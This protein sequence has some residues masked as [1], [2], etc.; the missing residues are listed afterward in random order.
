MAARDA[1]CLEMEHVHTCVRHRRMSCP[2][3]PPHTS[4]VVPP[5][6]RY[7]L[8]PLAPS[9][10]ASQM[11]VALVDPSINTAR[12][13]DELDRDVMRLKHM[14]TATSDALRT[15]ENRLRA[16]E[17]GEPRGEVETA[18]P[19]AAVA[20]RGG[21]RGK[22][23]GRGRGGRAGGG[24]A[25]GH[26]MD[27]EPAPGFAESA[28]EELRR[29]T[30]STGGPPAGKTRPLVGKKRNRQDGGEAPRSRPNLRS[31]SPAGEDGVETPEP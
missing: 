23:R 5:C 9:S 10:P 29:Q 26:G 21:G 8:S 4:L 14:C 19:A 27:E 20:G 6:P 31:A 7:E 2:I 17:R 12:R 13:L 24:A 22:G 30:R 18:E 25:R 1:I 3:S 15:I 16:V 28:E 11:Q